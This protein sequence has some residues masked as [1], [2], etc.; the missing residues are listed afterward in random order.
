VKIVNQL[1]GTFPLFAHAQGKC[2]DRPAWQ[3]VTKLVVGKPIHFPNLDRVTIVTFIT[4]GLKNSLGEQLTAAGIPFRNLAADFRGAWENK[5]KISLF[6]EFLTTVKTEF[7][8]SLD[9]IDVLI[10]D[11]QTELI[12]RFESLGHHIFYGATP[13]AFPPDCTDVPAPNTH[14]AYLN[15]GT[16]MGRPK[17]LAEFYRVIMED[18]NDYGVFNY[19]EQGRIKRAMTRYD[20]SVAFDSSCAL[21]QTLWG[22]AY[23]YANH[24]LIVTKAGKSLVT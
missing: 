16:L 5:V 19:S 13:N 12:P 23:R 10:A 8:L 11:D 17:Q 6:H 21:F 4:P 3:Q 24:T 7:V 9:S 14:W 2:S 18:R 15:S 20:G 22:F 1:T